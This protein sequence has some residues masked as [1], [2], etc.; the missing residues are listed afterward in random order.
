MTEQ[1]GKYQLVRK[2]AT[3][4]MAEVFL[5]KATG[6]MGFEKTLVLKRILVERA[7]DDAFIQMFL[8]EARLAARLTHPHIAQ[9]FDFGKDA[10]TYFLTMEY[11][12]GPSLRAVVRRAGAGGMPLPPCV[13]A[14]LVSRACEGLAF[15]HDFADPDTGQPLGLVHRDVSPDNLLLSRQGTVKVVDFGIAKATGHGDKTRSGII[16]GKLAYMP[17]EQ[18]RARELDRRVDVYALGVVLYEL[19]TGQRPYTSS[20]EAGL[21]QA[22]LFEQPVPAARLRPELPR[23]LR[24]ILGKALAKDRDERYPD[25]HALHADL[26]AFLISTGRP[27]TARQVARF[28]QRTLTCADPSLPPPVPTLRVPPP[29]APPSGLLRPEH[30]R[31]PHELQPSPSSALRDPCC[32]E[33]EPP[34][35]RPVTSGRWHRVSVRRALPLMGVALIAMGSGVLSCLD[36]QSRRRAP[37]PEAVDVR[38][39]AESP[40]PAS[41]SRPLEEP[42]LEAAAPSPRE[43]PPACVPK[44]GSPRKGSLVVHVIPFATVFVDGKRVGTTPMAPLKLSAGS[45]CLEFINTTLGRRV[46]REVKVRAGETETLKFNLNKE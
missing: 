29:A 40:A 45:H 30:T 33:W 19:L 24:R 42:S 46:V 37:L 13:C 28:I 27:V 15:A 43:S 11:V 36:P 35:P 34:A 6:P 3:G 25:C 7:E 4:G 23:A 44:P 1:V 9:I 21:M 2:L 38:P 26:E 12:D 32:P 41:P 8:S 39:E 31:D 18:I 5:A 10:D 22:I 20:S 16:K 17:P 14:W